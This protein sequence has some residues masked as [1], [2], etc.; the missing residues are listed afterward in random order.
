M[1]EFGKLRLRRDTFT[2]GV[3]DISGSVRK[4]GVLISGYLVLPYPSDLMVNL[5]HCTAVRGGILY[6]IKH[7]GSCAFERGE[8]ER[9]LMSALRLCV[10]FWAAISS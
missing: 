4:S 3:L 8:E 2:V 6:P 9:E 1:F 5:D 10:A 7:Q